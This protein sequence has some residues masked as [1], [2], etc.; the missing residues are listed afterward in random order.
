MVTRP[1]PVLELRPGDRVQDPSGRWLTV[2]TRPRPNRSGARLSWLYRGGVRG[3]AHW[4]AELPCR[5]AHPA[6]TAVPGAFL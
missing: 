1:V 5:P 4:L 3:R 2:A 6:R